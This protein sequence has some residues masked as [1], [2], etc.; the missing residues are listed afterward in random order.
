MSL[1]WKKVSD[2]KP[3]DKTLCL[4]YG[5]NGIMKGPIM[6]FDKHDAWMELF[7]PMGDKEGGIQF[8][9]ET[10]GLTHWAEVNR[11]DDKENDG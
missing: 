11:P 2:E 4:M 6:W 1:D 8:D 3:G 9:R 5:K 7:G 10:P